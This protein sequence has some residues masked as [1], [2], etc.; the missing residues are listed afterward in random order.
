MPPDSDASRQ[1]RRF[2][3]RRRRAVV[4]GRWGDDTALLRLED[5][6]TLEAAVPESLRE[7]IDVGA[8]AT[9]PDAG[10]VEWDA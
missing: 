6:T 5:G 9:V 10:E 2:A 3:S 4:I 7:S 8:E 1:G